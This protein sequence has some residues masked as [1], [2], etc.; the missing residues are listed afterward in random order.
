MLYCHN[1]RRLTAGRPSFCSHCQRSF[2]VKLCPSFHVN[3]RSAEFCS[4]CGSDNL[5]IPAPR[6]SRLLAFGVLILKALPGAALL[7]LSVLYVVAAGLY[8]IREPSSVAGVLIGA[9]LIGIL[10]L[11]YVLVVDAVRGRKR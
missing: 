8:L 7:C 11:L 2:A 9:L 5:S 10:W 4:K 1:C 3:P 6:L